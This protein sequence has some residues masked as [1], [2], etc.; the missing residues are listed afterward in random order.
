[1]NRNNTLRLVL[2]GLFAFLVA[3]F[4]YAISARAEAAAPTFTLT[5]KS[6]QPALG[7]KWTVDIHADGVSDM[8][9]FELKLSFDPQKWNFF[10]ADSKLTGFKGTPLPELRDT[11]VLTFVFTKTGQSAGENGSLNLGSV[12]FTANEPGDAQIAL[13]SVRMVDSKFEAVN[14]APNAV[15]DVKIAGSSSPNTSQQMVNE[16]SLKPDDNGK[17]VVEI[18]AGQKGVLLPAKAVGLSDLNKLEVHREDFYVAIDSKVLQDL[19]ALLK[20][21]ELEGANISVKLERAPKDEAATLAGQGHQVAAVMKAAGAV[22]HISLSIVTRDG[23]EAKLTS[24]ERPAE[25]S[26]PYDADVDESLLGIYYFNESL[27]E[28]EY[29]GGSVDKTGKRITADAGHFSTYGV[30]EFVKTFKDVPENHWASPAIRALAAKHVASGIS[31]TEFAPANKVTRAEFAA[32]L[33]RALGL[34]ANTAAPFSDVPGTSWFAD[35]IAAAYEAKLITG[36][37]QKQ[38]APN[39]FISREE[40]AAMLVRAFAYGTGTK[41]EESVMTFADE[42]AVSKWAA[43]DVRAAVGSGLMNGT[44]G[45]KFAPE[46]ITT[47]AEAAQAVYNLLTRLESIRA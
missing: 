12:T 17:I 11:G 6:E 21:E 47:R 42:A 33:T 2:L 28:W 36:K 5:A 10:R 41:A 46:A 37:S 29:V 34:K 38:F 25:L 22:Y 30:F 20:G 23:Q 43:D 24:F 27:K 7:N 16:E 39:V 19:K 3:P 13:T 35:E 26:F 31:D 40:M 15:I 4:L 1:M 14:Y 32:L 44:G 9:S 18:A 8:V 45:G